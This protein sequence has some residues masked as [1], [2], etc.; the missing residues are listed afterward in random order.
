L[1]DELKE[2][3]K[4]LKEQEKSFSEKLHKDEG[5]IDRKV[6]NSCLI[7]F[8][9]PDT[10]EDVKTQ[11]LNTMSRI[12]QFSNDEKRVIGL[13]V[14]EEGKSIGSGFLDFLYED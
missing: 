4:K 13:S 11:I 3:E 2:K 5:L 12:L 6:I 9:R 14:P 10:N 8:L 7:Q 1:K